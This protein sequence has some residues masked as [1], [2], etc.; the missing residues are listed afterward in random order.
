MSIIYAYNLATGPERKLSSGA[1]QRQVFSEVRAL[2][3]TRPYAVTLCEAIN[4][5]L[6]PSPGYV[7]LRDTS[8]PGRENVAAYVKSSSY[9][10]HRWVDLKETWPRT[11]HPGEHPARSIL[12]IR[13]KSVQLIAL[14]QPPRAAGAAA[15]EEG[16]TAVERILKPGFLKSR[17][18]PRIAIGDYNARCGERFG[19]DK[20]SGRVAD[21]HHIDTAVTRNVRVSGVTYPTAV[22]G[23]KL[24]SDHNHVLRLGVRL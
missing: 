1:A 6:L 10:G 8:T 11:D 20:L 22:N 7:L 19:P 18:R 5:T 2:L 21:C 3:S 14:H 24:S 23:L 17:F 9:L 15:M 12:V 4:W 16:L 13:L